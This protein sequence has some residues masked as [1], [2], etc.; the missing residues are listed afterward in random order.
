MLATI[1][2]KGKKMKKRMKKQQPHIQINLLG[3]L[4]YIKLHHSTRKL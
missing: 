2:G 4:L 3:E 1:N